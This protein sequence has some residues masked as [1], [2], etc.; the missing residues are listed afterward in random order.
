MDSKKPQQLRLGAI[1]LGRAFRSMAP[2]LRAHP[3]VKLVAAADKNVSAVRNCARDFGA[4]PFEDADALIRDPDIDAVY[5][6]TPHELHTPQALSAFEHGKH[7]IVEKPMA[8]SLENCQT[9][10][11]AAERNQR[12]LVVGHSHGFDPPILHAA[13]LV[14]SGLL[15]AIRMVNAMNYTDWLYRPRRPEE[16]VPDTAGVALN[17]ASHQVDIIRL[18]AGGKATSVRAMCGAWDR[19]RPAIGAYAALIGFDNGAFAS[20]CYSGY[21]YFNS[22]EFNGW[23]GE[24]GRAKP[25]NAHGSA[26]RAL[27]RQLADQTETSIKTDEGYASVGAPLP[28]QMFGVDGQ[29]HP[30]FGVILASCDR[31]DVRTSAQ[32]VTIFSA[33]GRREIPV[34]AGRGGGP[35]AGVFD[36]LYDAAING[37]AP[38]HSGRWGMAN[39]EV[40]LAIVESWKSGKE[41]RLRHQLAPDFGKDPVD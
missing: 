19:S 28:A 33:D 34:P 1:G 11:D 38:L 37:V 29:K 2:S 15:G 32:G 7:V 10:V 26:R 6:A 20:L 13:R 24:L 3:D 35:K 30:Q 39:L 40:C 9:M 36:Q 14:A 21:D 4:R 22:D 18:L 12:Y 27:A 41:I 31:G 5:I 16:L 17:Q 23:I 8:L 25:V